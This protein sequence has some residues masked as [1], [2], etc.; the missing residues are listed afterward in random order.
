MGSSYTQPAAQSTAGTLA[1]Y[2]KYLPS[3]MQ[4]TANG[5]PGVAQGTLAGTQA[6]EPAYNA[7]NL[8][9][10]QQFGLP[11]AQVGQQIANSNAQAGAQTNLQQIQGAGGQAAAAAE[12]LARGTNPDYYQAQ[13]AA[14]KGAASAV[15]AIDLGGLSPGEQAATERGMNQ[16]NVGTGNLGVLN[17]TNTISNALNFGGAF[18]SKV[19][20]MNNAVGA[21]SGA[22]NSAANNGGFNAVN[23]A[24]GQP[25]T[26]TMSNFGTSA[27][28]PTNSATGAGSAGNAFNFGSGLLGNLVSNQNQTMSSNTAASNAN[29]IPSYMSAAAPCC[30]IFLAAYYGKL[31]EC[32]RIRRDYWYA[33]KPSL[34]VGYK[35]MANWLVPLMERYTLCRALVWFLMIKPLTHHAK[36]Y[37]KKPLTR[38]FVSFWFSVWSKTIHIA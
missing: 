23:V 8:S 30:F 25:N 2:Q 14:S 3:L 36:N 32:V 20:L 11:E 4:E 12:A 1:A 15:G 35:K 22:A 37:Q 5:I 9:Q 27:F 34:S 33:K 17:P 29:S 10:L 13:D 31:P 19:G 16:S 26:S 7:L 28:S 6:T 18:N 21:A 24:L 38:I